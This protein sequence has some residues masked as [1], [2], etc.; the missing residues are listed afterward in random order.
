LGIPP[1]SKA[2]HF[3]RIHLESQYK[4]SVI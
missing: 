2:R 1:T 3:R 4:K